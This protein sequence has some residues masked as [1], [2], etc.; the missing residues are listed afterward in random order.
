MSEQCPFLWANKN[1]AGRL[2]SDVEERFGGRKVPVSPLIVVG[3]GLAWPGRD[4]GAGGRGWLG[5]GTPAL[6]WIHPGYFLMWGHLALLMG[7]GAGLA[8][9]TLFTLLWALLL[10]FVFTLHCHHLS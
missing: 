3:L 1:G 6:Q 9:L 10:A 2:G 5:A 7:E 8:F 4:D